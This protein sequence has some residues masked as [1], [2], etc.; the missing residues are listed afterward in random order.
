MI[1]NEEL[2]IYNFQFDKNVGTLKVTMGLGTPI[3][4][5]RWIEYEKELEQTQIKEALEAERANLMQQLM[6]DMAR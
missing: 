3:Q 4:V 6:R 1:I 2:P 5:N